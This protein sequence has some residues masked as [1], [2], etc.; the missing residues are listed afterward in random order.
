MQAVKLQIRCR[1]GRRFPIAG[2]NVVMG[3]YSMAP[4]PAVPGAEQE[5]LIHFVDTERNVSHSNPHGEGELA[6]SL[7][8]MLLDCE[9]REIGY[10]VN[11]IDVGRD[12]A[13]PSLAAVTSAEL[14]VFDFSHQLEQLLR[15]SDQLIKQQIRAARAYDLAL[16]A[17]RLDVTLAFLLLVTAIE[18]LSSQEEVIPNEELNKSEKSTE[19]F[20][21]VISQYCENI[22]SFYP[23]D[24]A[25]TS[26]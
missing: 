21:R 3:R 12:R 24:G 13:E 8:S 22:T 20:C 16:H 17:S 11:G 2:T 10:A 4:L 26:S 23:A 18:C 9:V 19:R 7:L 6:L 1:V 15:S 5:A 14:D 25:D